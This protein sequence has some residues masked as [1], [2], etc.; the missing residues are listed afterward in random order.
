MSLAAVLLLA[1]AGLGDESMESHLKGL[2]SDDSAQRAVAT[3]GILDSWSAWS[4]ADLSKLDEAVR[5]PDPDFRSRAKELRAR[6]QI[7]RTVGRNL[8]KRVPRVDDAFLHGDDHAKLGALAEAKRIWKAGNLAKDDLAG[9]EL[10]VTRVDWDDPT[11]LD[12]FLKDPGAQ[13]MLPLEKNS[14]ARVRLRVKEVERLGAQ[15]KQRSDQVAGYLADGEPEVR[16]T[17]L[18]VIGGIAAREQAPKVGEMLR[19]QHAAVRIEAL[20]L[21]GSWNAKEFVPDFARLL[22]DPSSRVRLRAAEVLGAW[23]QRTAGTDIAKLLHDPFAPTRAEAAMILGSFGAREFAPNLKPLLDDSKAIVRRSAAYALGRFGTLEF[24]PQ[25]KALLKDPDAEVRLTAAHSLGEMDSTVQGH[26]VANLLRDADSE[27]QAEAAWVAG[28]TASKDAV[29]R[30]AL[31]VKDPDPETRQ[32]A[33]LALGL[34]KSRELRAPA[35]ALLSDEASWVRAEA[36]LALGRIGTKEEVPGISALLRDSDRKVRVSAALALGEL[37][38]ADAVEVL[39]ALEKDQDRLLRL[40][41]TLSLIRLGKGGIAALRSALKELA[42]DDLAFACLGTAALDT[43]AFVRS[44]EAWTILDR[45]LKLKQSVETWT[46]LSM[47]LTD[48]GLTLEVHTNCSIGRLDKSYSLAGRDAIAWLL[49]RYSP[50]ALVVENRK[51]RLM[52]RREG[53]SYWLTRLEKD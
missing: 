21:L 15:G 18:R 2:R 19:D 30:I 6:I 43:A 12:Q 8:F 46:D 33:V 10:L 4:A 23:G 26:D 42:T 52:G 36:A 39:V 49:G 9:L 31:L 1:A 35:A 53:L 34:S 14:E 51:V 13:E 22:K 7:R 32:R 38:S 44:R 48:A 24:G 25:L 45:P 11:S 37:G 41:S 3:V 40:A 17:A 50:P 29:E 28:F 16:T 27:V 5:D 20:S 47:A